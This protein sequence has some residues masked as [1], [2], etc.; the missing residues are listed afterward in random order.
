[1][2]FCLFPAFCGQ[3]S[4]TAQ[5]FS[6]SG[7]LRHSAW[8]C[9]SNTAPLC[10]WVD[11]N[12]KDPDTPSWLQR[13]SS[14][15]LHHCWTLSPVSRPKSCTWT[16]REDSNQLAPSFC[17]WEKIPLHTVPPGGSTLYL[18]VKKWNYE[19]PDCRY[20]SLCHDESRFLH[21]PLVNI[22]ALRICL[23]KK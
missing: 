17:V 11:N 3:S 13:T 2:V 14:R 19:T 23:I 5:I 22:S 21:T 8:H 10:R 15:L 9:S 7:V 12:G 18:S 16:W 4:C 1:M 20:T 6:S